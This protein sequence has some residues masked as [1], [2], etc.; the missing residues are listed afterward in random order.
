MKKRQRNGKITRKQSKQVS[1][2]PH[3][4]INSRVTVQCGEAVAVGGGTTNGG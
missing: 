4:T 1:F 2:H 3:M